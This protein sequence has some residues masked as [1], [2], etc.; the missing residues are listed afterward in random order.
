M[1][2]KSFLQI[3]SYYFYLFDF[4]HVLNRVRYLA[5]VTDKEEF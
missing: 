3:A 1:L 4:S 5:T 2:K